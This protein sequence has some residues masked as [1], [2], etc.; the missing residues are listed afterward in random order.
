MRQES[1]RRVPEFGK[2]RPAI[3]LVA[4]VEK[5]VHEK[6]M[7]P[8]TLVRDPGRGD[9]QLQRTWSLNRP[10][11]WAQR[12][13]WGPTSYRAGPATLLDAGASSEP[14]MPIFVIG[15]A[16]FGNLVLLGLRAWCLWTFCCGVAKRH[17]ARRAIIGVV[18]GTS[19]SIGCPSA[20]RARPHP[21][22]G[23]MGFPEAWG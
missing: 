20:T 3:D 16:I 11:I 15:V 10:T 17:G 21:S 7:N 6:M 23:R 5:S 12:A 9:R 13:L 4:P 18:Q 14:A 2:S 19:G 8:T 1:P 22:S